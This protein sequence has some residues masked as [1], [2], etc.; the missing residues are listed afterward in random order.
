M[1]RNNVEI[2]PVV[3]EN[4]CPDYTHSLEVLKSLVHQEKLQ[5]S[6][7]DA[8]RLKELGLQRLNITAL[9]ATSN[10]ID[11]LR[12]LVDGMQNAYTIACGLQKMDSVQH[13]EKKCEYPSNKNFEKQHRLVSPKKKETKRSKLRFKKPN[14]DEKIRLVNELSTNTTKVCA[15]CFSAS[16]KMGSSSSEFFFKCFMQM[17][18]PFCDLF[19]GTS[20]EG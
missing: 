8:E 18:N 9:L 11:V 6:S 4:D 17:F 2:K 16:Y 5:T 13:F 1:A 19:V 3:E 7:T 20:S 15:L 10:N 12:A 14:S